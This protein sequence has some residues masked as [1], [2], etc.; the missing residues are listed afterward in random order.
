MGL[1]D[2][3]QKQL[4]EIDLSDSKSLIA[5][6]LLLLVPVLFLIYNTSKVEKTQRSKESI[7]KLAK[8]K[9]RK[10]FSFVQSSRQNA[11][12]FSS[13]PKIHTQTKAE[14]EWENAI[15]QTLNSAKVPD[16][17]K[18]LPKEKR[19]YWEAEYD[20]QVR[21]ANYEMENGNFDTA[22]DL[23]KSI[24][25]RESDNYLLKFQ[26]SGNLCKMY[27]L[28]GEEKNFQKEFKR[29]LELLEKIKFPGFSAGPIKSGMAA[30]KKIVA[31]L[32]KMRINPSVRQA[33]SKALQERGLSGKMIVDEV[34]NRTE[35]YFREFAF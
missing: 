25:E 1:F 13:A 9:N 23:C 28:Q 10:G 6:L 20:P 3:F 4:E 26:A 14:T 32:P 31:N 34:F 22:K 17:I 16:K 18:F 12:F 35:K 8:S 29:Y 27:K 2:K 11:T 19:Q 21:M 5:A 7:K 15:E 33:V 30:M 24:L